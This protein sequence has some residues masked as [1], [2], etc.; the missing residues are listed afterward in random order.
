ME[1]KLNAG[2]DRPDRTAGDGGNLSLAEAAKERQFDGLA[3]FIGQALEDARDDVAR[4]RRVQR[5]LG[6]IMRGIFAGCRAFQLEPTGGAVMGNDAA[7]AINRAPTT[8]RNYPTEGSTLLRQVS[9][10]PVPDLDE[11]L[12]QDVVHIGVIMDDAIDHA[13][14]QR[15]VL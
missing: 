15:G 4:F 6:L 13:T 14:K 2:L 1:S 7:N 8:Q 9:F 5:F 10:R 3:L 12:L 11:D